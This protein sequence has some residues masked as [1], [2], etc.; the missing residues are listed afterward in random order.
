MDAV[1]FDLYIKYYN[2]EK[3]VIWSRA[4]PW[5]ELMICIEFIKRFNETDLKLFGKSRIEYIRF[6]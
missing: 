5:A 2:V 6:E 4:L 3:E 1:Y